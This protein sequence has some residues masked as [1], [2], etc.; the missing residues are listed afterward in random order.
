[1]RVHFRPFVPR[2]ALDIELQPSQL[3]EAGLNAGAMSIEAAHDLILNGVAWTAEQAG[4]G[5]ILCC[6]GFYETFAGLQAT[7]WA[8]LCANLGASAHLAITRFAQA[9]IAESPLRRIECMVADDGR[10]IRWA[11]AV[12][13][14]REATL[15]CWGAASETVHVH[16]RII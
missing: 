8:R 12:G 14:V 16:R 4:S 11:E 10:A 9:R 15:E 2:D 5:R 7:A 3:I 13:L 1:M 6:A